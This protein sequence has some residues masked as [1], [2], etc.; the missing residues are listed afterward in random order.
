MFDISQP[1]NPTTFPLIE[2]KIRTKLLVTVIYQN[3]IRTNLYNYLLS[4]YLLRLPL[5]Y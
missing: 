5:T 4:K 1:S 3:K 2:E